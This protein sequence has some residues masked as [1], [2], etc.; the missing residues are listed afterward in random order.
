MSLSAVLPSASEGPGSPN[1]IVPGCARGVV[2]GFIGHTR[3]I[4]FVTQ[5]SNVPGSL[6][7]GNEST[8]LVIASD[9]ALVQDSASF[10]GA[11]VTHD[12]SG[13]TAEL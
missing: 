2:A 9:L 4:A 3:S 7:S 5:L 6:T 8:I 11:T 10:G 12:T 1:D 13:P